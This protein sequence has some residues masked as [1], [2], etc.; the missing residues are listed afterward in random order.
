MDVYIGIDFGTSGCRACAIDRHLNIIAETRTELSPPSSPQSGWHEQNPALWWKACL[1]VL[2]QLLAD[3]T[4]TPVSI[5]VDG[6]SGTLLLADDKGDPLT[7]ALMYNDQRAIT[8]AKALQQI[9]PPD[10]AVQSPSSALAKLMY[11]YQRD[12]NPGSRYALHQADW[13]VGKLMNRFGNSDEN[14][15]LKLGYDPISRTWPEWIKGTGIDVNLLPCV[16]PVG[17]KIGV[18]AERA[19]QRW[20]CA[21][22]V[23]IIA[24]T[25]DS[26]AAALASGI[27]DIGQAVT[28]LGST[29]VLKVLSDTPV[30]SATYGV[31]SHRIGSNWL[32][33]GAS[34]SGGQTLKKF[35]SQ[36]QIHTMSLQVSPDKPTGL[37]Y[38]PLTNQGERFPVNN[39]ELLPQFSPRPKN[40]VV[41]FQ[42]ILEGIAQI[43]H[44]GYLKLQ[45][46]GAPYPSVIYSSGGG[47]KNHQW[48]A[49]RATILNT[50]VKRSSHIEACYGSALIAAGHV[51][52]T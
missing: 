22:P 3:K 42:G 9:A 5:S 26:N 20:Q 14:N 24:G 10:T 38:Y 23:D 25:T 45:E 6:T 18:L 31:Y 44:Q 34:N 33:G 11:L 29:L 16:F 40:D 36:D 12:F 28:S 49:I 51:S 52:Q 30:F 8:Q 32:I 47:A 37:N 13:I 27:K 1:C 46:L 17:Q 39:P 19:M 4:L 15:A 48:T 50:E 7:P 2:D 35:F 41:F 43:E 21:K